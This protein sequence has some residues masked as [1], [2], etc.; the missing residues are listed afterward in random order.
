MASTSTLEIAPP[1]SV[2]DAVAYGIDLGWH[3]G[4]QLFAA[5]SGETVINWAFGDASRGVPMTTGTRL[6]WAC[7]AKPLVAVAIAQLVETGRVSW[8]DP[9]VAWIPEL[10]GGE[11]DE[12]TIE[13]LLTYAAGVRRLPLEF[14]VDRVIAE[15]RAS[16]FEYRPGTDCSYNGWTNWVLLG[17]ILRRADRTELDDALRQRVCEPIGMELVTGP[18]DPEKDAT[19]YDTGVR[20]PRRINWY[21]SRATDAAFS[22][23]RAPVSDLGAFYVELTRPGSMLLSEESLKLMIEP[24]VFGM[25]WVSD[26]PPSP[27]GMGLGFMRG[28]ER[29]FS[30]C[31]TETFGGDAGDFG[32]ALADPQTN[33]VVV[34]IA[35]G[36]PGLLESWAR[37]QDVM[38]TVFEAFAT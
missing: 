32:V 16:E 11:R 6:P 28:W 10:G 23:L 29:V 33:L 17:E 27:F 1:P 34:F 26:G 24:R 38:A 30:H 18:L 4:G 14:T 22:I 3:L 7:A 5:R 25:P 8:N 20:P 12:I 37:V 9:V 13:Q 19:L 31:S 21:E 15:I 36:M 2:A 35:N